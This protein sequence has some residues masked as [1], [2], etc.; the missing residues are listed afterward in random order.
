MKKKPFL[1][2]VV[3]IS[4]FICASC[5]KTPE[6][7]ERDGI[8]VAVE[9]IVDMP[10]A[11]DQSLPMSQEIQSSLAALPENAVENKNKEI[12]LESSN[13]YIEQTVENMDG[14]KIVINGAVNTGDVEFVARYIYIS[15]PVTEKIREELFQA[16]FGERAA[17]V[18][19]DER[20]DLWRLDN[21]SEGGDYYLYTTPCPSAGPTAFGEQVFQIEYRAVDL[22]PFRDNLLEDA[23][24]SKANTTPNEAVEL[25]D[26]IVNAMSSLENM[27]VDYV[28]AYGIAGRRPYYKIVYKRYLDHLP[29]T[30]Y[31]DLYFLVDDNGI[32][33]IYGAT[34]D[35]EKIELEA[36]ILSAREAVDALAGNSTLIK[37][38]EENSIFVGKIQLE[39]IVVNS[40]SGDTYVTPAW[41]FCIGDTDHKMNVLRDRI[42]AV[43]AVTGEIIQEERGNTF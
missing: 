32:E 16:Y 29:V 2:L 11:M 7:I 33:K 26:T 36:P 40:T 27:A 35:V 42:L 17:D 37:F 30:G 39:Y 28:H 9:S 6:S 5:V 23:S 15:K 13:L 22:Y 10:E 41:R 3:L 20:N 24:M 19:Y 4:C 12:I 1:I 18:N 21:S 25:C 34:Y 43:D 8:N 31:N 38:E 14:N